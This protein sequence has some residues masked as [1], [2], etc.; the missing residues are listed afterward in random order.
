MRCANSRIENYYPA[1]DWLVAQGYRVVRVGDPTMTPVDRPGIVDL[2]TSPNRSHVLELWCTSRC[3]FMITG[4]SGPFAL[5]MLFN[6]PFLGV[7]SVLNPIE[8]YPLRRR[9]KAVRKMVFDRDEGRMLSLTEMIT[10]EFLQT[11]LNL[12]R[13]EYRD[14]TEEEILLAVQEMHFDLNECPPP[15][16]AQVTYKRV[17]Q[18]TFIQVYGASSDGA[19][20]ADLGDGYIARFFADRHVGR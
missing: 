7:N 8:T 5:H 10:L 17:L 18:K 12:K 2:A 14:N 3:R 4:D 16:D 6:V 9:D 11:R 20:D 1:L 15:S 19:E 13:Y